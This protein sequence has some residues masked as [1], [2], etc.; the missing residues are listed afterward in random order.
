MFR[1]TQARVTLERLIGARTDEH[2]Q[3]S[4][5]GSADFIST[6]S[7]SCCEGR[8]REHGRLSRVYKSRGADKCRSEEG[9]PISVPVRPTPVGT[10]YRRR[11]PISIV[12]DELDQQQST[13]KGE[14][15]PGTSSSSDNATIFGEKTLLKGILK[16]ATPSSSKPSNPASTSTPATPPSALVSAAPKSNDLLTAV[17]TLA[18]SS[19]PSSA[20]VKPSQNSAT[21][22][23]TISSSESSASVKPV[24]EFAAT[25]SA[26][27]PA[28]SEPAVLELATSNPAVTELAAPEPPSVASSESV[29]VTLP[30]QPD[31]TPP[32]LVAFLQKWTNG[33]SAGARAG[34]LFTVPPDSIPVLFGSTLESPLL[35]A[36][37]AALAWAVSPASTSSS[38]SVSILQRALEYMRALS[39]VPR[40][41]QEA[42][43][44]GGMRWDCTRLG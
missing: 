37:L 16:G 5:F 10:P 41:K 35:G 6:R 30:D 33:E 27:E 31:A 11:V 21:L 39:R 36:M 40:F 32:T 2:E 38:S 43:H 3:F 23:R 12:D 14:N 28:T 34:V 20:G 22:S 17:S 9:T 29:P 25:I 4:Y 44:A 19:I 8:A 26:S 7:G 13:S 42:I 15:K 24:I 1:R 18:L